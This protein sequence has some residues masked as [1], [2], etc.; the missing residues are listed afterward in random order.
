MKEFNSGIP[1]DVGMRAFW[2]NII[3]FATILHKLNFT[4]SHPCQ[5]LLQ[6]SLIGYDKR[7][8]FW[9]CSTGH[10]AHL[11]SLSSLLTRTYVQYFVSFFHVVNGEFNINLVKLNLVLTHSKIHLRSLLEIIKISLQ[12]HTKPRIQFFF[13][14]EPLYVFILSIVNVSSRTCKN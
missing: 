5:L 12:E 14:D 3:Y 10:R 4:K 8:I 6:V 11:F 2:S 7:L 9:S 1:Q 13:D